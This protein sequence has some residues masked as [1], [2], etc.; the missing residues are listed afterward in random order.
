MHSNDGVPI[1]RQPLDG[2]ACVKCGAQRGAYQYCINCGHDSSDASG[3]PG[4]SYSDDEPT[5][6]A[7]DV[8]S[9]P[10]AKNLA[11]QLAALVAAQS[12]GDSPPGAATVGAFRDQPTPPLRPEPS[13]SPNPPTT[14]SAEKGTRPNLA[15]LLAAGLLAFALAGVVVVRT[16]QAPSEDLRPNSGALVSAEDTPEEIVKADPERVVC[17]DG[18]TA[19][20]LSACGT[21]SGLRGI[22]WVFPSILP[23]QCEAL[24]SVGRPQAWSCPINEGTP[25]EASIV[26]GELFSVDDG[27]NH[28][29]RLY[30]NGVGRQKVVDEHY[31][32]K[33]DRRNARDLWQRSAM[34][35]N[36]PWSVHVE[37]QTKRGVRLAFRSVEFR[38]TDQL[39]GLGPTD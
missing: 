34:Y 33:A 16:L 7:I 39:A 26:Y 25:E 14:T 1:E 15:V 11:E 22:A 6:T 9:S 24:G 31:V 10:E 20:A 19:F 29:T 32:W 35:V 23:E 21:P 17:W 37:A 36:Q 8:F 3:E 5:Q 28:Y 18:S 30:E 4:P 27:L 2:A 38:A 13:A 12:K